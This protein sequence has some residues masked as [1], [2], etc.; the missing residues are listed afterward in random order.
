MSIELFRLGSL[1]PSWLVATPWDFV[2]ALTAADVRVRSAC[3]SALLDWPNGDETHWIC[4]SCAR[5]SPI[6][7]TVPY[8]SCRWSGLGPWLG[9]LLEGVLPTLEASLALPEW[10]ETLGA[11][12]DPVRTG[13][14]GR[15]HVDSRQSKSRGKG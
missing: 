13:A 6:P 12:R 2:F 11:L 15:P 9:E 4:S 5:P 14:L 1:G 8:V 7:A 3:C 10:T